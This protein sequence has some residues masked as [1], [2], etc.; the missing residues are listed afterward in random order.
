MLMFR[1]TTTDTA[2]SQNAVEF[3]RGVKTSV[4]LL[5]GI[6]PFALV[7][8]AQATQ[9]GFSTLEMPLLTGLNFAGGSEFAILEMWSNPPNILILMFITFLVNSRHLLMGAS[10]VPY[11]RHLPNKTVFP[12]LFF[13]VDESWAVSLADAQKKQSQL[14]YQR[15]FSMMFYAGLCFALY[16]MWVGFTSLGAVI[17]PVLGDISRFGFDMAFPAVFLVLLRSMWK[18]IRAARPW[19][20][21]LITAALAYLYLP[22]GWYVPI[23]AICG[24][25]SAFFLIGD[26]A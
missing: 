16:L 2:P 23:G 18:G 17:G 20:V 13:M 21:S 9:K 14:G 8:G 22:S 25:V 26:E 7:L 24:I 12:A 15:A 1:N 5:L 4:P 3:K 10:L 6:I 19:L 11:L